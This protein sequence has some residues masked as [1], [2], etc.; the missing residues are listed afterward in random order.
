MSE[1]KESTMILVA[2]MVCITL[3]GVV[4]MLTNLFIEIID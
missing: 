4:F 3:L 2:L 1:Y